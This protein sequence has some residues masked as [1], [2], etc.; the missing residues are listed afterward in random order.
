MSAVPLHS[1]EG[2]ALIAAWKSAGSTR[3]SSPTPSTPN[4]SRASEGI[5]QTTIVLPVCPL[6]K[7]RQTQRDKWAKRPAVLRYR[8]F[9]DAVRAHWPAGVPFPLACRIVFRV[10]IPKSRR[11]LT[12][13][14]PHDQKPDVDNMTKAVLDALCTEDKA[15]W[16]V[17]AEKRWTTGAG[18]VTITPL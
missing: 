15:V 9:C 18:S 4:D 6:G 1:D 8:A 10:P 12:D 17:D 7:P 13:D 14:Q 3:P 11:D 2:R 5:S 16:R